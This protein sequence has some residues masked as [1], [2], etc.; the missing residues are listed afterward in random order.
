MSFE[1][2]LYSGYNTFILYIYICFVNIFPSLVC[3]SFS[4]QCLLKSR[5]VVEKP[6]GGKILYLLSWPKSSLGFFR[7]VF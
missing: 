3:L 5:M 1:N 7:N 6:T 2:F 4:N